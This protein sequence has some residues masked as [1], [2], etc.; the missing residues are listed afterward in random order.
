MQNG[1]ENATFKGNS[2]DFLQIAFAVLALTFVWYILKKCVRKMNGTTTVTFV[3]HHKT[4]VG[5]EVRVVGNTKEL[6]KWDPQRTVSMKLIDQKD[7]P[8]WVAH[9]DVK[10]PLAQPIEYK[11][12]LMT[13]EAGQILPYPKKVQRMGALCESRSS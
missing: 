6:G 9:L 11:Y 5:E 1:T 13:S 3:F 7:D 10:F 12:V 4:K 8:V 2:D